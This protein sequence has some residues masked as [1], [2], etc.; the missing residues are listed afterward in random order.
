MWARL[1]L[2]TCFP[3]GTA[4]RLKSFGPGFCL[5]D[6][7]KWKVILSLCLGSSELLVSAH[8]AGAL[9]S[10]LDG[11]R[12]ADLAYRMVWARLRQVRWHRA[13]RPGQ[14]SRVLHMLQCVVGFGLGS[15]HG[16]CLLKRVSISRGHLGCL[17]IC[18]VRPGFGREEGW[19][20]WIH[21]V[22]QLGAPRKCVLL[23]TS[24]KVRSDM[25]DRASLTGAG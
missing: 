9:L 18:D 22:G 13:D 1:L 19:R 21:L 23:T 7:V 5:L 8:A 4:R 24:T 2:W 15:R 3:W 11:L 12:E 6:C 16:V 14:V 10:L 17:K 25:A 20:V